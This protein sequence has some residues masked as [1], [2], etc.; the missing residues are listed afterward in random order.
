MGCQH[1][2][3]TAK[4][5]HT[6]GVALLPREKWIAWLVH[7]I[8]VAVGRRLHQWRW[9]RALAKSKGWEQA[10]G[11]VQRINWDS[12]LPREEIAFADSTDRGYHSRFFWRWFDSKDRRQVQV[13]NRVALRYDPYVI[14]DKSVFVGFK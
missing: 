8:R 13:G 7:A 2:Y 9:N 11:T 5:S 12:S 6:G 1:Y 4:I 10:E 14:P 3:R